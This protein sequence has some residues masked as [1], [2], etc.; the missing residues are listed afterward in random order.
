MLF[1]AEHKTALRSANINVFISETYV[2]HTKKTFK[3][4]FHIQRSWIAK[5]LKKKVDQCNML[6]SNSYRINAIPPLP[7]SIEVLCCFFLHTNEP[8]GKNQNTLSHQWLK[9]RCTVSTDLFTMYMYSHI[10]YFDLF[11]KIL[12]LKWVIFV[13]LSAYLESAWQSFPCGWWL[14][15]SPAV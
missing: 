6:F 13:P 14:S 2:R 9:R 11:Y 10:E 12:N 1:T 5:Y 3:K 8:Y 7:L 15:F 4:Y